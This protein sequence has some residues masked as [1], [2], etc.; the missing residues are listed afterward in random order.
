MNLRRFVAGLWQFIYVC[1]LKFVRYKHGSVQIYLLFYVFTH[2]TGQNIMLY[3]NNFRE[4]QGWIYGFS[5][6][7]ETDKY[8]WS[9]VDHTFYTLFFWVPKGNL[10]IIQ[11]VKA[12]YTN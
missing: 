4:K 2:C 8:P 6:K 12:I 1:T 9:A 3:C 10:H 5:A 11:C 7:S